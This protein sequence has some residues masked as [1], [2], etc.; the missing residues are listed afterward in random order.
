MI[1][2]TGKKLLLFQILSYAMIHMLHFNEG[3]NFLIF[4][5]YENFKQLL[6]DD[7]L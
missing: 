2:V 5:N 3:N 6:F 1:I 4:V 7:G